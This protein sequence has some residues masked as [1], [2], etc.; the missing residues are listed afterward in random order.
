MTI[1]E[2]IS[3]IMIGMLITALRLAAVWPSP[4]RGKARDALMAIPSEYF[5]EPHPESMLSW[6]FDGD[7][8]S[9]N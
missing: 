4:M 7:D 8:L 6:V 1:G 5:E 9:V 3:D 2:E